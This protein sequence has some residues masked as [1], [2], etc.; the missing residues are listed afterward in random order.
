MIF[1]REMISRMSNSANEM[2]IFARVV[3][4]G[5]FAAAASDLGLSPSAVS[6]LMSR[7]ESR[8]DVRLL[9]RTTRRLALT[10]EGEIFLDRSRRILDA[11]EAAESEVAST[12][13]AAQ[14]HLRVHAFPTFAV[15]HLSVALPE[16]LARYPRIT[17]EFLVTNRVVDLVNDNI[18][19]ALRVGPLSDSAFVARKIADLT[20]VVCAS[21]SYLKRHGTPIHPQDLAQHVCLTLSHVP[22]S[23]T[24]SFNVGGEI[25]QVEVSGPVVA[26]SAHMLLGLAINGAGI[27]RFGD[28]IVAQA[29][30]ERWLIP[31]LENLQQQENFPLWAMFLPGRQRT[32][33]IK[34]FLDFLMERFGTAAWRTSRD[35]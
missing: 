20:Q 7:L 25:V 13:R 21:P 8:L 23:R 29:I 14:G 3:D 35:R 28:I 33:R 19:I 24:W 22:N 32:P 9:N 12:R 6:K 11:I 4:R 1:T 34:A 30:Q 5:S 16:F 2:S 18:D 26:D 15:D 27:I 17:F 10:A 31:V